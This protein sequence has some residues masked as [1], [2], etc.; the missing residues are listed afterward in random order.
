MCQ[1]SLSVAIGSNPMCA[2]IIQF[3]TGAQTSP[4]PNDD[5]WRVCPSIHG[6]E[7]IR[8]TIYIFLKDTFDTI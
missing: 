6:G 3:T 8:C 1:S 5:N 2:L 4:S 7:L